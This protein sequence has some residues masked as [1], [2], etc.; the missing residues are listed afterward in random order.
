[1]CLWYFKLEVPDVLPMGR[2]SDSLVACDL[3]SKSAGYVEKVRRRGIRRVAAQ[4]RY[5]FEFW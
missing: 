1:M 5:R 3:S 4:R 2:R